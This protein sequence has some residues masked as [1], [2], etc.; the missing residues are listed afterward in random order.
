VAGYRNHP[1]G[2]G[3]TALIESRDQGNYEIEGAL[4]IGADGLHSALRAQM[5]PKQP[6]FQWGGTILWRGASYGKPIRTGAS[7]L[8]LGTLDHRLILYPMTPPDP[9]TG[10]SHLNWIAEI[11]VK[12]TE[13]M[14]T[15]DWNKQVPV[16]NFIH[17]FDGWDYDWLDVPALI[18]AADRVYEYPMI[19]RDPIPSWQD[20]NVGLLGDAAHVMYPVGSNGASQ[21]IVDARV[22]GASIL[23]HGVTADALKA[24]DERLCKDVSKLVLRARESG[25]F[26]ILKLVEDRCGG[27]FDDIDQVVPRDERQAFMANYKQAAG[28]AIDELNASPPTI[29]PGAQVDMEKSGPC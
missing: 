24:Y 18:R 21:A 19:D 20:G 6:P 5:Y 16:D 15:G 4:L 9:K 2:Q 25:P 22:L 13:V 23:Q 3:V 14:D 26:G 29:A 17:L 12:D 11:T 8:G 28:F 10:L 7:F 1:D 27:V